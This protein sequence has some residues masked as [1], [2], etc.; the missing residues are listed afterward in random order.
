MDPQ[1]RPNLEIAEYG[2]ALFLLLLAVAVVGGLL[3]LSRLVRP[4]NPTREKQITYECGEDPLGSAWLRF[5]IRFYVVALV[6]VLFDVEMVLIYPVAA[7]FRSLTVGTRDWGP[8]LVVFG[9]LL[10]FVAVLFL[11]LVYVWR[12]GDLGWIRS[13]R[14]PTEQGLRSWKRTAAASVAPGEKAG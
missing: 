7:I 10:F 12:K 9:E 2:T 3:V 5:N 11:G 6:F 1:G 8:A 13:F 4:H 14:V